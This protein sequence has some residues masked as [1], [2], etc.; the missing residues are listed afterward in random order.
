MLNLNF[1]LVIKVQAA[2]VS[3]EENTQISALL[4]SFLKVLLMHH[5]TI[6]VGVTT[7][8]F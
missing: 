2:E 7:A 8:P 6:T 1:S 3:K 5:I 4:P